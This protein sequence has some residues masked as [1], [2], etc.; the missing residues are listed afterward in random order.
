M[1]GGRTYLLSIAAD[2]CGIVSFLLTIWLL[3]KSEALRKE[4]D[5]QRLDYQR[6]QKA[7]RNNI[8]ALRDNIR[9]D[10]LINL[11]IISEVRTYLLSFTQRFK[12]LLS[13]EDNKRIIAT[14]AMLKQKIDDIDRAKLCAELDYFVARFDKKEVK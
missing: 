5:S 9:N 11:R 10:G 2:I 4:I 14:L 12:R 8:I 6:E 3:F 13:K 1:K 7:I